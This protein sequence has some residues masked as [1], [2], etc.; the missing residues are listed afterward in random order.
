MVI[1]ILRWIEDE[2]E[3]RRCGKGY[4]MTGTVYDV[5]VCG[6]SGTFRTITGR[7]RH[8]RGGRDGYDAYDVASDE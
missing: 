7:Q 6:V 3:D 4:Y 5:W 2:N 1:E 8:R